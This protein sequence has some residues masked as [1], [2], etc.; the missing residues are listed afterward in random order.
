MKE[1]LSALLDGELRRE[2][3]GAQLARVRSEPQ[4]RST[5][6]L[7]CLIG[8]ALRGQIGAEI[9]PHVVARLHEEPTVLAPARSPRPV[10]RLAWYAMSAAA[11]IAAVALVVWT[12]AP[13]W[14]IEPELAG[15]P[16]RIEGGTAA[17]ADA[18]PQVPVT[19]A[20]VE[21]YLLAHQPYSH[22]SAMQ[23]IAPYVRTVADE[24][25]PA[26]K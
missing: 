19:A 24:G 26:G 2:E 1:R 9:A 11:S 4:L 6:D 13:F 8:D 22:T 17:V 18:E 14:R 7:Y 21:N 10:R 23:G 15:A 5:W 3:I 20:D 25:R 16:A 12:A